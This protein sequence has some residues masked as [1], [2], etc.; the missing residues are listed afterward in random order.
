V[1]T[2]PKPRLGGGRPY[3]SILNPHLDRIA[4]LRKEGATWEEVAA[5]LGELGVRITAAGARLFHTRSLGGRRVRAR[6][7]FLDGRSEPH[8]TPRPAAGRPAPDSAKPLSEEAAAEFAPQLCRL[9]TPIPS[10]PQPSILFTR[11]QP[12]QTKP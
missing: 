8:P 11:P 2:Q 6:R 4:A 1:I 10:Q 9:E 7:T 12:T 3:R 5:A